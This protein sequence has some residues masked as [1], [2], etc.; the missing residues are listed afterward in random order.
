M[1]MKTTWLGFDLPHPLIVGASPMLDSMDTVR[2]LEDAGAAAM[3]MRSLF[4]EQ[5]VAEELA[6]IGSMESHANTSGEALSY[7]PEA[8][9]FTLGPH[10]YL[11]QIR[12]IKAAVSVPVVA[13]LNGVGTGG[14][15]RYSKLMEE[16]GADALELNVYYVATNA[17]VEGSAIEDSVLSIVAAV[18]EAVGIPVSVKLSPYY[19]SVA[20]LASK[21]SDAGVDGLV[22]F[23]RFYQPDIDIEGI[24]VTRELSLST[25]SD[26]LLRLRWLAIKSRSRI[27]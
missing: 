17:A 24:E 23:N 27:R 11:E 1:D 4:E 19:S 2:R 22:L 3:V 25:S 8:A 21:L 10:E 7:F 12:K 20:N 9:D 18:R 14:W 13:S 15:L 16:A 26:L 5:I 6:T